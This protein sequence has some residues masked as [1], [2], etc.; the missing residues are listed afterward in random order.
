MNSAPLQPADRAEALEII[1]GVDSQFSSERP[2]RSV[3]RAML[4][5]LPDVATVATTIGALVS[6][7][8]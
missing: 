7:A 6:L 1:D 2:K 4:N 3:I 5:A 8:G